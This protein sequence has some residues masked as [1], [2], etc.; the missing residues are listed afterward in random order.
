[1]AD[2]FYNVDTLDA[3]IDN[4]NQCQCSIKCNYRKGESN[5][6]KRLVLFKSTHYENPTEEDQPYVVIMEYC[7]EMNANSGRQFARRVKRFQV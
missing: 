7:I 5:L 3:T 2:T 1:M 6:W 4:V